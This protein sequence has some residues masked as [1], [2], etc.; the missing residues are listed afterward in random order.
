[1]TPPK[2][3][4]AF[5]LAPA[6]VAIALLNPVAAQDA[7]KAP[8]GFDKVDHVIKIG[9]LNGRLRFDKE[10]FK[11]NPGS[12]VKLTLV[13]NDAM[14][15]NLLIL[16][17][18]KNIATKIG[19]MAMLLGDQAADKQF[20]PESPNVLFH[21]AAI[22]P[23][24]TDTIWFV[25]P[26]KVGAYPYICT[27]P[28]HMFTMRGIMQV[29]NVP[30]AAKK[31]TP[32]RKASY[33]FYNGSWNKLP[34]FDDLAPDRV[35][36]FKSG[37]FD[38]SQFPERSNF[39]VIFRG[40]IHVQKAG[41]YRFFLNSD[42]GSR[43]A[44]N[45][46]IVATYDGLHGLA[47]EHKADVDLHAGV[48]D[49]R[50][51]F[52]QRTGGLGLYVACEGPEFKRL[53]LS[54]KAVAPGPAK[55]IPISVMHKPVVMRVHLENSGGRSI[56]VGLPGGMNFCFDAQQGSVKFG[57]AGA[58]IDVGPDRLGRGGRP[59]KILGQRFS[60]GDAG[61]P[62]RAADGDSQPVKFKGYRLGKA[63]EFFLEWGGLEVA[64]SITN[65]PL[66]I[67]LQYTYKIPKATSALQFV[68]E[69]KGLK[70]SSSAGSFEGGTLTV[71]RG[72]AREFT[73]TVIQDHGH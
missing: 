1:M 44:V 62:L 32:L 34:N 59:C 24:K 19:T 47:K 8:A 53:L 68:V 21:T 13:N 31:V 64:C 10:T 7:P 71:P 12:K 73:V 6:L 4:S 41:R 38:L 23:G 40:E 58:Y 69:P 39:G 70:L 65:A 50:V 33:L 60:V 16:R 57:W 30:L 72:K 27:L 26:E 66:G 61:F 35:G 51:E 15:H 29:G 63:P 67:G 56:A 20:V 25:A 54:A 28:G 42:D 11:V 37:L 55:G 52:F 5:N 9:T 3:L 14:Q 17:P 48:N 43:M 36:D 46:E 22:L 49:V 18:G 45:G 2:I